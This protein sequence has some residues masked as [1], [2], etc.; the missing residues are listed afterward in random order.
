MNEGEQYSLVT[1][2]QQHNRMAETIPILETLVAAH[3]DNV[4]YRTDLMRAYFTTQRPEQLRMLTEQTDE[5]LHQKGRWIEGNAA[6]FA[7]GCHESNQWERSQKLYTEVIALH[8]RANQS[9]GLNDSALSYYYQQLATAQSR[10]MHTAAAVEAASAAIICWDARN[11][12]RRHVAATLRSVLSESKDLDAYVATLDAQTAKTGQDSPILRRAIGEVYQGRQQFEKAISQFK[13]AIDLQPNDKD[14]LQ[15]LMACYDATR[16]P[17][18]ATNQLLK[19]IDLQPHDLKL[20]QQ[21]AERFKN[22]EVE[23]ERAATSI[24]ESSPNESESHTAMAELRQNQNRWDEAIPHWE[25][26]AKLRKLEP[27]GLV[28]LATAQIHEKAVGW[29]EG[30]D[31]IIGKDRMAVAILESR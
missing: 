3:A 29:R 23:A 30:I 28:R 27:T 7:R 4:T 5:Y 10:L 18:A 12:Q 22:N 25:Q 19:L 14:L 6:Q 17:D 16:N 15:Q 11:D 31:S 26:V 8:Q 9:S 24:I 1:W 2:L 21:L 13:L 20:Y